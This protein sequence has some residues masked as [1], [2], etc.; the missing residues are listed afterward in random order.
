MATP[1]ATA[2]RFPADT[3]AWPRGDVEK[4]AHKAQQEAKGWILVKWQWQEIDEPL[5][6]LYEQIKESYLHLVSKVL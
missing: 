4:E 6:K 5:W 2:S 1:N 3:Q